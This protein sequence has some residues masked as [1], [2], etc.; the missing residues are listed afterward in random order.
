MGR[1]ESDII[2]RLIFSL[3]RGENNKLKE[4]NLNFILIIKVKI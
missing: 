1:K 3:F 2:E 4:M